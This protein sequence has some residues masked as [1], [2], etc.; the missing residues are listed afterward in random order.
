MG[1]GGNRRRKLS[2][3][4]WEGRHRRGMLLI[5]T[6][7]EP[8]NH[9]MERGNNRISAH[10]SW[11]HRRIGYQSSSSRLLRSSIHPDPPSPPTSPLPMPLLELQLSRLVTVRS[12][13]P[14]QRCSA[15]TQ[16]NR[17]GTLRCIIRAYAIAHDRSRRWG[18]MA[19]RHLRSGTPGCSICVIGIDY[20]P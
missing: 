17:V 6:S 2:I 13:R 11:G 10:Y 4:R 7:C 19:M 9:E 12:V 16:H 5:G 20:V 1:R 14:C 15:C 3:A 8:S 18:P